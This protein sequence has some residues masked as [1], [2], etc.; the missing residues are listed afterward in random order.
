MEFS[1]LKSTLSEFCKMEC[2]QIID[3]LKIGL[4]FPH[5]GYVITYER[6]PNNRTHGYRTVFIILRGCKPNDAGFPICVREGK[7]MYV[8]ISYHFIIYYCCNV[9]L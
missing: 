7:S 4:L 9:W 5:V 1:E 6:E 8:Y 2:E 3:E